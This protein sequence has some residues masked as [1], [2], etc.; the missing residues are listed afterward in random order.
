MKKYRAQNL[1]FSK[2]ILTFIAHFRL[3]MSAYLN[4]RTEILND[5]TVLQV[6]KMFASKDW[7]LDLH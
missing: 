3:F 5:R 7:T 4:I 6:K 2:T 1:Q